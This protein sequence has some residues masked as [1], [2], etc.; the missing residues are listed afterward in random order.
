[1]SIQ[2]SIILLLAFSYFLIV[3]SSFQVASLTSKAFDENH[4][5]DLN[6]RRINYSLF[7]PV[8]LI[9]FFLFYAIVVVLIKVIYGVGEYLKGVHL[10]GVIATMVFSILALVIIWFATSNRLTKRKFNFLCV[11]FNLTLTWALML[12]SSFMLIGI[13]GKVAYLN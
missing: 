6:D 8:I 12:Y 7:N 2:V 4:R 10:L 5:L 11:V 9:S 3:L 1:M 13:F